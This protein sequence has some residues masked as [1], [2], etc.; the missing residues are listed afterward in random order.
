MIELNLIK[1]ARAS[2]FFNGEGTS[3]IDNK[4]IS[5]RLSIG[6]TNLDEL[7]EFN[8]AIN[9]LG[10]IYDVPKQPQGLAKL[11]FWTLRVQSFEKV[12]A[13]MCMLWPELSDEKRDQYIRCMKA[14]QDRPLKTAPHRSKPAHGTQN[15]YGKYK[16]R[17]AICKFAQ[18][19]R[20][21]QRNTPE[22]KMKRKNKTKRI[23]YDMFNPNHFLKN[24]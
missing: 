15:M 21:Q 9:W 6:N 13:V 23:E 14:W 5:V 19:E 3:S 17:C 10:T 1:L 11:P 4:W 8:K 24:V 2:G 7:E 12:Q 16:C 20:D 18:R 22:Q